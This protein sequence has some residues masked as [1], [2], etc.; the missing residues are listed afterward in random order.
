MY[1]D[2]L[3]VQLLL[4]LIQ[5]VWDSGESS[6]YL[7]SVTQDPVPG[8]SEKEVLLQVAVAD[9][10]VTTLGAH[11]MARAYDAK[12]IEEPFRP[13]WGLETVGSG[14]AGSAL[15]EFDYGL[16]EPPENIPPDPDT[17]PHEDPRRDPA[18]QL[19]HHCFFRPSCVVIRQAKKGQ[20]ESA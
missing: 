9:A 6:G 16:Y 20:R 15:V 8:A 1:P 12:L 3:D 18:G 2:A 5:Q 4:A 17:D 11:I 14:H 19:Q 7:N 10:Q 13:I